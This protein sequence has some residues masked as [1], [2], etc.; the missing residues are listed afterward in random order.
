MC[1]I[2]TNTRQTRPCQSSLLYHPPPPSTTPTHIHTLRPFPIWKSIL[3]SAT[4]ARLAR[5]KDIECWY[6]KTHDA[7]YCIIIIIVSHLPVCLLALSPRCCQSSRRALLPTTTPSW[8]GRGRG[9]GR[10]PPGPRRRRVGGGVVCYC[11]PS[12]L[13]SR[14][15]PGGAR[16]TGGEQLPRATGVVGGG[17][18]FV[19]VVVVV[20]VVELGHRRYPQVVG[21]QVKCK[22]ICQGHRIM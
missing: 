11:W 22:F 3:V 10:P 2:H 17:G 8:R 18:C 14:G 5:F 19:V 9:S 16:T 13:P 21:S 1:S 12:S 15:R 6:N 20:V 4:T 7:V